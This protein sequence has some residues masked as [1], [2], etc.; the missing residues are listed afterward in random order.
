MDIRNTVIKCLNN[1]G[2]VIECDAED[3][4]IN[5]YNVDS[6]TFISFI[7]D[8]ENELGIEIPDGYLYSDILQSLNGFLSLVQQLIETNARKEGSEL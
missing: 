1:V 7:I 2:I 3:V 6:I 8:I 4:N 5:D